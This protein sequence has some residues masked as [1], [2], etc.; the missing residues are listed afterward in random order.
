MTAYARMKSGGK[1]C[2]NTKM[3]K[4][5][6]GLETTDRIFSLTQMLKIPAG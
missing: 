4:Q 1:I 5:V 6:L 2:N 3:A